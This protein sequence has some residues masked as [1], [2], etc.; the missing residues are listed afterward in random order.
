MH[1]KYAIIIKSQ[2]CAN[3]AFCLIIISVAVI[4]VKRWS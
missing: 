3:V 4:L 1:T 2:L